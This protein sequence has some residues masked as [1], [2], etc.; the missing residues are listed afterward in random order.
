[1]PASVTRS[2]V[3]P[4]PSTVSGATTLSEDAH[5][6]ESEPEHGC[7]PD[8]VADDARSSGRVARREVRVGRGQAEAAELNE[9]EAQRE[10]N[11][12]KTLPG[13]AEGARHHRHGCDREQQR[14]ALAD[15]G[16]EDI[17]AQASRLWP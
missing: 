5:G 13:R 14:D 16:Q 11:G 2:G 1:M 8:G 6:D 3:Q 9:Q 12:E 15:E 4:S 10:G 17:C 7:E